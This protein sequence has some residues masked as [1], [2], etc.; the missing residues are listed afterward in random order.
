[1][2]FLAE[3]AT[4]IPVAV[5]PA[6]EVLLLG[7]AGVVALPSDVGTLRKLAVPAAFGLSSTT[8]VIVGV[9]ALEEV[10]GASRSSPRSGPRH[11]RIPSPRD[12]P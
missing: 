9:L 10:T 6:I 3:A 5:A 12:C 1:V 7:V 2:T 11:C 8:G 4:A